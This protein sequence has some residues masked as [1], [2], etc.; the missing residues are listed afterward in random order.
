MAQLARLRQMRLELADMIED[1][2]HGWGAHVTDQ[3][4]D[5]TDGSADLAFTMLAG[6]RYEITL[7]EIP[8]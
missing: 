5:M 1:P 7:R 6:A 2:Q 4:L 3:G 8:Q